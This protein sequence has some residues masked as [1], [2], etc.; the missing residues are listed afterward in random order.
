MFGLCRAYNALRPFVHIFA[1]VSLDLHSPQSATPDLA[2]LP[3]Q[4]I[5]EK[6]ANT[7]MIS[8]GIL[9]PA[10]VIPRRIFIFSHA[11]LRPL[12]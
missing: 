11:A 4:A 12:D 1:R 7:E 6:E 9:A 10:I 5:A 8:S 2:C 3:A